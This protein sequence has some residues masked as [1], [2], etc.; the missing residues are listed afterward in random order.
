MPRVQPRFNLV[1]PESIRSQSAFRY[2]PNVGSPSVCYHEK[3]LLLPNKEWGTVRVP[4]RSAVLIR[5][6]AEGARS[7]LRERCDCWFRFACRLR[8]QAAKKACRPGAYDAVQ[9]RRL[10][11]DRAWFPHCRTVRNLVKDLARKLFIEQIS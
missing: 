11:A 3:P 2:S 7:E 6:L 4:A 9:L 1:P 10:C 5:R 8:R